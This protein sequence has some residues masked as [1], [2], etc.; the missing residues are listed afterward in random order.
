MAVA[1]RAADDAA[2]GRR[3]GRGVRR[4]PPGCSTPS[5]TSSARCSRPPASRALPSRRPGWGCT[6]GLYPLGL[7]G[8]R[9]SDRRAGLP[10]RAPA[11]EPAGPRDPRRRGGRDADPARARHGRQP[12][13][14]HRPAP[15]PR[16]PRLRADRDDELLDPHRRHPRGGRAPRRRGRADRRGDRLRAHPRHRPLDGRTHRALL[17]DPP[18]RRRPRAH[19]RHA[20][21][22]ACRQ[23]LGLRRGTTG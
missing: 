20:R 23:H 16:A 5:V 12:L 2:H 18:R 1:A 17:R 15:R 13:D 10:P 4:S 3:R 19:P 8:S 6:S 21:H 9:A 22:P 7:L 11:A 14:L